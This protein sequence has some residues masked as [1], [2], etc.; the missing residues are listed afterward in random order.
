[1]L[2]GPVRGGEL[3]ADRAEDV[4]TDVAALTMTRYDH[5]PLADRALALRDNLR[6]HLTAYNAVFIALALSCVFR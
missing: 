3:S 5:E 1:M 2:R 6:D 4:R